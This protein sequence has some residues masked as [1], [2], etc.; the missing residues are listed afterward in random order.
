MRITKVR[1]IS[2]G[3]FLVLFVFLCVV[4]WFDRLGGYPVNLFLQIDPLVML[5]AELA[6]G[7]I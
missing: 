3:F 7:T 5:A 6:G 1:I 4:T 2:Q